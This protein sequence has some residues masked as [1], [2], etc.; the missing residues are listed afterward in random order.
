MSKYDLLWK[1]IATTFKQEKQERL[2]FTF[3]EIEKIGKV[4]IDHSFLTSKKELER[5]GYKVEKINLKQ[6]Q[7]II[8]KIQDPLEQ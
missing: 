2:T 6:K 7:I 5:L 4:A 8:C 1:E 3:E